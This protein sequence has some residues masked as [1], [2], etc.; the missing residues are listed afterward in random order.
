MD[1]N[2]IV[3][4]PSNNIRARARAALAGNWQQAAIAMLLY[5]VF[6]NLI[7]SLIDSL[8]GWSYE[9]PYDVAI[10]GSPS[11]LY[12]LLV[13][14]PFALGLVIYFMG[15][16]RHQETGSNR[17]FDGF[18]QF[19]KAFV[20]S[21]LIGIFIFLWALLFIVPGII[22]Y[23][24][25][26]QAFYILH[27]NPNLSAMECINESKRIMTG[28]KAKLFTLTLSFIG[29][30][31]LAS[32]PSGIYTGSFMDLNEIPSLF[33]SLA[34]FVLSAGFLWVGAYFYTARVAFYEL[35]KGNISGQ[36]YGTNEFG[37][38]HAEPL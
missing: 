2:L 35:L 32:L 22:A 29:W 5:Y 16:F 25:Y 26:S 38:N 20:L 33:D 11:W 34:T 9:G 27:D 4:E 37:G 30:A 6:M 8:L 36:V 3:L 12:L 15:L 31:I 17:V 7:P 18:N 28:N 19:G 13:T 23:F 24:R 21:L 14:G 10:S 1:Q